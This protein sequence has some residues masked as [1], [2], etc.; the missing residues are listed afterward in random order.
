MVKFEKEIQS[1]KNLDCRFRHPIN[2]LQILL[3]Q[4]KVRDKEEEELIIVE[5]N[6]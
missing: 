6:S 3:A 4:F 1:E 2:N 5:I